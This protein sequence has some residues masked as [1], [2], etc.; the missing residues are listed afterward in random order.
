M[1]SFLKKMEQ[2]LSGG[3]NGT[4]KVKTFRWLLLIGLVGSA[5]MIFN[6]FS[7]PTVHDVDPNTAGRASPENV[8]TKP[9]LGS[10]SSKDKSV[11]S[12]YEREYEAELRD[13]LQK[14]VGVGAVEVLVT[15]DSTEEVQ[16]DKNIQD[17]QQVTTENDHN[18]ATRHITDV[19]RNG[20]SVLYQ[21]SGDQNPYVLKYTKPKIRGVVVVAN[22]VE[23][24][25]VKKLLLEAVERG[26]DVPS[27]RISILPRKQS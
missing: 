14:I 24:L 6:T 7:F 13:I 27:N 26:L 17:T 8:D 3:P 20:E 1:G 12:E 21:S 4:K 10:G 11:F 22:G 2:W 19:T 5:L 18:G 15:I 16:L 23:N 9:T 25:T